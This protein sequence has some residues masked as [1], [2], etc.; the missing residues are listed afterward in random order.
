MIDQPRFDPNFR[1]V[2][3]PKLRIVS[4]LAHQSCPPF[5]RNNIPENAAKL[6][7]DVAETTQR[8]RK[9]HRITKRRL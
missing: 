4:E 6:Q 9:K 3:P 2:E 1:G 7:P 5:Q 8:T